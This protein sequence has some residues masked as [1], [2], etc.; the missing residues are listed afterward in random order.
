M[1]ELNYVELVLENCDFV[2]IPAN[3][4]NYMSLEGITRKLTKHYF[5]MMVQKKIIE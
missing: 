4:I 1:K 5:T 2:K 3:K